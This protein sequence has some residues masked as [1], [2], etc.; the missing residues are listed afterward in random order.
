[1]W[2]IVDVPAC[3]F[4]FLTSLRFVEDVDHEPLFHDWDGRELGDEINPQTNKGIL[5]VDNCAILCVIVNQ[6]LKS[7]YRSSSYSTLGGGL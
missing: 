1:M 2:S 7:E 6:N 4:I 5:A 3:M